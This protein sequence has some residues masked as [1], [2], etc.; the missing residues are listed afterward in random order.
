MDVRSKLGHLL[1]CPI[2]EKAIR[3][4]SMIVYHNYVCKIV[5]NQHIIKFILQSEII[6][7]INILITYFLHLIQYIIVMRVQ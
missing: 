2:L 7:A 4:V 1:I 5:C 3:V 6:M